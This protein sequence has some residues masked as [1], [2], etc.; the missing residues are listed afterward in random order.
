MSEKIYADRKYVESLINQISWNDLADKPFDK[1]ILENVQHNI[2]S[3]DSDIGY[4]LFEPFINDLY[5]TNSENIEYTISFHNDRRYV[6]GIVPNCEY[7]ISFSGLGRHDTFT[8]TAQEISSDMIALGNINVLGG[9]TDGE[10]YLIIYGY[11]DSKHNFNII[12]RKDFLDYYKGSDPDDKLQIRVNGATYVWDNPLDERYIPDT[13][14]RK[15]DIAEIN[16]PVTSVNGMTGDVV[17]DIPDINA[18]KSEFILNSST[19]DST[20]QFKLTIDDT[21]T[22]TIAEIVEE[23]E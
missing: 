5:A 16:I 6:G 15:S 21:G 4:T 8:A 14:A 13:I 22:L 1:T 20:K 7:T 10:G 11:L 12:V 3:I 2:R 17:I 9:S 19:P 18:P 23:V